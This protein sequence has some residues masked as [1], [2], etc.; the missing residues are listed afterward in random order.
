MTSGKGKAVQFKGVGSSPE[1][2]SRNI[3]EAVDQLSS[4]IPEAPAAAQKEVVSQEAPRLVRVTAKRPDGFDVGARFL[5]CTS[6]KVRPG[7]GPITYEFFRDGLNIASSLTLPIG[8]QFT[9][10]AVI[11]NS[12]AGLHAKLSCNVFKAVVFDIPWAGDGPPTSFTGPMVAV[13]EDGGHCTVDDEQ[14]DLATPSGTRA[15][16]GTTDEWGNPQGLSGS[17]SWEGSNVVSQ[18][19]DLKTSGLEWTV[20][21]FFFYS[22]ME[23]ECKSFL[24][25]MFGGGGSGSGADSI[26]TGQAKRCLTTSDRFAAIVVAR[27][28][29]ASGARTTHTAGWVDVNNLTDDDADRARWTVKIHGHQRV[30]VQ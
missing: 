21:P 11:S 25:D 23:E 22:G 24:Q 20:T 12:G 1:E 17:A 10:Q 6:P 15:W 16:M 9:C 7:S 26:T 14:Y 4:L 30:V 28:F 18:L 27:R 13:D 3:Q 5:R 8:S 2:T 19:S 29:L